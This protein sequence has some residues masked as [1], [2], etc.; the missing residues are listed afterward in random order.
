MY[1]LQTFHFA[2][3]L[4]TY[5]DVHTDIIYAYMHIIFIVNIL[6]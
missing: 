5:I 2:Y 6:Y 1:I 4:Y 3:I